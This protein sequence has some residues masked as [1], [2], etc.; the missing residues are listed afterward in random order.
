MNLAQEIAFWGSSV[1]LAIPLYLGLGFALCGC[2]APPASEWTP[3]D[4]WVC[5]VGRADGE[6]DGRNCSTYGLATP[7]GLNDAIYAECYGVGYDLAFV[8][9]GCE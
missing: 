9:A 7:D 2:G 6:Q 8:M 4:E 1:A 3:A 5:E